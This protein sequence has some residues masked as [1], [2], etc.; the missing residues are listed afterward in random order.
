SLQTSLGTSRQWSTV[1]SNLLALLP[2]DVTVS[3]LDVLNNGKVT[4]TGVA[5]TRQSFLALDEAMKKSP[6][7]TGVTTASQP[8]KRTDLPF[9]YTAV[10]VNTP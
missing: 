6:L 7:L 1:L 8:S 3:S 2:A 10:L 4:L 5:A 9:S